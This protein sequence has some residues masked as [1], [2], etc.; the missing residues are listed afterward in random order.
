LGE[1]LL[2]SPLRDA[3]S[4]HNIVCCNHYIDAIP[5]ANDVD[6]KDRYTPCRDGTECVGRKVTTRSDFPY[7]GILQKKMT[8]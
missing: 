3:D 1:S 8:L 6:P 2:S 7:S 5:L 4:D